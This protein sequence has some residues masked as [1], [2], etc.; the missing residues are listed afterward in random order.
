MTIEYQLKP[1]TQR[2]STPQRMLGL[3]APTEAELRALIEAAARVPDHGRLR[4]WRLLLI[5]GEHRDELGR[6]LLAMREARS[7]TLDDATRHK[8]LQRFSHAPLVIAVIARLTRDH[9]IPEVEQL[10]SAAALAQNLLIGACALGYGA[11]W[12]TG[13]PAYDHDALRMLGLEVHEQIVGFIHIG[14]A[15]SDALPRERP[16]YDQLVQEWRST[17]QSSS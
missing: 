12:L 3:P 15:K 9:K 14:T 13:W 2:Q 6:A 1:L 10:L 5:Q 11:N 16:G 8:D 7:D 4:P 17:D